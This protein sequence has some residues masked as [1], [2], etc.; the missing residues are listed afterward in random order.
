MNKEEDKPEQKSLLDRGFS[1]LNL[2]SLWCPQDA[3]DVV[4]KSLH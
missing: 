4:A 1:H 2:Q 3:A